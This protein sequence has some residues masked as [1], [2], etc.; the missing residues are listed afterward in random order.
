[1]LKHATKSYTNTLSAIKKNERS[2]NFNFMLSIIDEFIK[3]DQ[4]GK[5]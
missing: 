3:S 1:L 2:Y 4:M 5:G